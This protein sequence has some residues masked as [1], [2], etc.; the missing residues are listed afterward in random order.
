M[1]A[2]TLD[3]AAFIWGYLEGTLSSEVSLPSSSTS[4]VLTEGSLVYQVAGA[5]GLVAAIS[6]GESQLMIVGQK[7]PSSLDTE[8]TLIFIL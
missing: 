2:D 1:I 6:G 4:R 8:L 7:I 3:V 5:G